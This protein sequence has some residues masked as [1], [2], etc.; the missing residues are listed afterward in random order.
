MLLSQLLQ[1]QHPAVL[2]SQLLPINAA[3]CVNGMQVSFS[4]VRRYILLTL[5]GADSVRD[6]ALQD[7][8]HSWNTSYGVSRVVNEL[9]GTTLPECRYDAGS[10]KAHE[11]AFWSAFLYCSDFGAAICA[12]TV[13]EP[14][15]LQ[16]EVVRMQRFF[17]K[18]CE[19]RKAS[20]VWRRKWYSNDTLGRGSPGR[21]LARWLGR[22]LSKD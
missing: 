10:C 6:E 21:I 9:L 15:L 5:P 17:Y 8:E 12:L 13:D 19:L 18:L 11:F 3:Q 22:F 16:A 20:C 14:E 4:A 1:Q 2:L 7:L